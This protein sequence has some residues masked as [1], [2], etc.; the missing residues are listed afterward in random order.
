[1][2]NEA[3]NAAGLEKRIAAHSFRAGAITQGAEAKVAIHRL[4][5]FEHT[6]H[7]QLHPRCQPAPRLG[8]RGSVNSAATP[9]FRR[10][11]GLGK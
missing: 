7:S 5:A 8:H 1:M 4:Q 9:P 10:R 6:H 11:K 3:V 2:D